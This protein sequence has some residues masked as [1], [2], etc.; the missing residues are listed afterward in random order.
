MSTNQ[1]VHI[2]AEDEALLFSV[3]SVE[4]QVLLETIASEQA[5]NNAEAVL[6]RSRLRNE[7]NK[8]DRIA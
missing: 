4:R 2:S 5:F 8:A 1:V 7:T 3:G 6:Y